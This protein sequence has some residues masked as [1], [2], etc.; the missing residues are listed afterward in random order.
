MRVAVIVPYRAQ[1]EQS[2][3]QQ[4]DVFLE[5]VP[6]FFESAPAE[7]GMDEYEILV[8]EQNGADKFNRGKLLNI[9][10]HLLTKSGN[11]HFDA[12]IMW[13]RHFYHEWH[14]IRSSQR[15]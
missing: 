6:A 8:V 2:R 9:G 12:F 5:R 10:F 4:L 13:S 11:D 7:L 15:N 1:A 3:A 14:P